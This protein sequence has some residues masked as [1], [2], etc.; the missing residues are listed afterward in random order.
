MKKVKS[1]VLVAA[2]M[3]VV[4]MPL[5]ACNTMEGLGQDTKAA[6]EAITDSAQDNKGY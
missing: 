5:A 6:G 1:Y 3:S 4:M 2:L